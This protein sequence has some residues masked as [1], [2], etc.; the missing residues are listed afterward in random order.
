MISAPPVAL[1]FFGSDPGASVVHVQY[2]YVDR[3]GLRIF[4]HHARIERGAI[5]FQRDIVSRFDA[6]RAPEEP[7]SAPRNTRYRL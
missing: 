7:S 3:L 5:G 2:S 6:R 1:G 4:Q